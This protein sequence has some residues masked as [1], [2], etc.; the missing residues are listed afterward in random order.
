MP[1]NKS[2]LKQLSLAVVLSVS[3]LGVSAIWLAP[4][5]EAADAK[6]KPSEATG[7]DY[8]ARGF[9]PE[10][11]A[12]W[13]KAVEQEKNAGAAF[14]LGEE[15]FDAKVVKRDVPTAV[16]YY[17]F[18]A[19]GGDARA[20]MDLGSMYDKGW[21]VPADAAKA[22]KWFEAAAQQGMAEAQ[23]NVATMYQSGEGVEKSNVKAYMYYLLAVKF[24]FPQFASR[25]L[26][27]LSGEMKPEEIKEATLAARDFKPVVTTV[28][29]GVE[30]R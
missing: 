14:R 21:G 18:G 27:N 8:Y 1:M 9:Y 19:D 13:K 26:E 12:E 7:Q 10:A 22:A 15:Y 28:Q 30:T 25:E 17:E 4:S 23:Y 11:L 6:A 29:N 3:A 24:G 5:V 16:K 20:Q 2:M